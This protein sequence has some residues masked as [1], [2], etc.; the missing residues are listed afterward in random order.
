FGRWTRATRTPHATWRSTRATR[1]PRAAP[2]RP[3]AEPRPTRPARA[4]ARDEPDRSGSRSQDHPLAFDRARERELGA[5][6]V[7]VGNERRADKPMLETHVEAQVLHGAAFVAREPVDLHE[8]VQ[9]AVRA[10]LAPS[11]RSEQ[12]HS[13]ES[14]PEAPPQRRCQLV[15]RVLLETREL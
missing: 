7:G 2:R 3:R 15:K 13:R 10:S 9:V 12:H 5:P 11:A 6:R 8:Q 1:R 4:R 14:G